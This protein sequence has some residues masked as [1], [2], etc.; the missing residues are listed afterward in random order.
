MSGIL[1]FT[2]TLQFHLSKHDRNHLGKSNSIIK[3]PQGVVHKLR[4]QDEVLVVGPKMSTFCQ[5]LYQSPLYGRVTKKYD[6]YR[7]NNK[8]K[9][10]YFGNF[11][12]VGPKKIFL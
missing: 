3:L 5:R 11:E 1:G 8:K 6:I 12:T 4:L 10:G 2:F 7:N 9:P